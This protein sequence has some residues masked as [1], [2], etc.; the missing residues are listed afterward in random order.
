[1]RAGKDPAV[2]QLESR[3]TRVPGLRWA[4]R[5]SWWRSPPAAPLTGARRARVAGQRQSLARR[6]T[7]WASAAWLTLLALSAAGAG[8]IGLADPTKVF[9]GRPFS[10]PSLGHWLGT[11]DLGRDLLS[12]I[13]YGARVSLVVGLASVSVGVLIGGIGGLV[14]GYR[15]GWVF[16][17]TNGVATIVLA[18]PPLIFLLGTVTFFG[19]GLL[20]IT[21]AIGLLST[22]ALFRVVQAETSVHAQKQY[23]VAA[24]VVGTKWW[25]I[26]LR[27]IVPD[28]LR[29]TLTIALLGVAL[30]ILAEG[31]LAFLGLSVALPTPSW[32]NMIAEGLPYLRVDPYIALLPSL[33]MFLT[34][35]S[36]H[37]LADRI[38]PWDTASNSQLE[39]TAVSGQ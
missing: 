22:P 35:L 34:V 13:V 38:D 16:H 12:R 10:G 17:V 28:V 37:V 7:F 9:A 33:A 18:F 20:T 30:A 39:A 26:V 4:A 2:A 5:R 27:E 36:L 24:R 1:M 3:V 25:D 31:A 19:H 8:R 6:V 11:D 14:S 15:R 23:V 21:L 32:G 29:P